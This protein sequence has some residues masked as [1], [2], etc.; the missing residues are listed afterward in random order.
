MALPFALPSLGGKGMIVVWRI[1]ERCNLACKFCAY[2]RELSRTRGDADPDTIRRFGAVLTQYQQTTGDSVLVS[3]LGGEPLL[4]PPLMELTRTYSS[5]YQ[6]RVSTTTNGT[7]LNSPHLRAHL[8]D[9]YSELTVSVDAI[10]SLHDNLRGWPGGFACLERD[11]TA[12]AKEKR[13]G[14]RGPTLRANV[15]L[16]RE[17]LSGFERLCARL[18]KWGIEEIT[19]N[20]LGG[21]DRPEYYPAHRLLPEHADWLV[22]ELPHLRD[23]L[24]S[25]G[26]RLHGANS[27]AR[28]IQATT[29]GSRLPVRDC[30]PGEIF[31]FI[32]ECGEIAPCSFTVSGYGIPVSEINSATA[33]RELPARFAELRNQRRLSACGDCHSTQVFEKFA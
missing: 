9:Y 26:L 32:N 6:L 27:Y 29:Y 11:M 20:Q 19:F 1:T 22:K 3:W 14:G 28:R 10:G 30:S 16:M 23:R 2:D 17:T 13:L 5:D 25:L 7:R 24:A 8:L 18:A 15:L 21:N 12:L 33:L 4:W 31:L